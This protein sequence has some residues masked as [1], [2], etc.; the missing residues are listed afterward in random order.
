MRKST[1]VGFDINC[2]HPDSKVAMKWGTWK[3]IADLDSYWN[4]KNLNFCD[5]ETNTIKDAN[6]LCFMRREE[7]DNVYEIKTKFGNKL[8]V[9]GDHPILTT[10]GMVNTDKLEKNDKIITHPFLGVEFEEPTDEFILLESD[11]DKILDE[12]NIGNEGN[13]RNQIKCY[14][15]KL[16]LLEIKY[17]SEKLPI[18]LKIIGFVLGDGVISFV[19]KRKGF[20]HF[21]GKKED[22]E[23][24]QNNIRELG[25]KC[26]E[27][28][29]RQ[30]SYSINTYYGN[31][32]F[33]FNETSI[34]KKS[35]AFAILL[36][37][38]GV[39]YGKK[40]TKSYRVPK[41][42]LKAPLWQKRLFLAAFFGA[43]LSKPAILNKYN[44]YEL[45]LNMNKLKILREN[46][47]DFLNDIRLILSEFD[48]QTSYPVDV[49]GYQYHG[50]EGETC[51][52]RL[53][54]KNNMENFIK[55]FRTVGYEYNKKKRAEACYAAAY[56]KMK[57]VIVEAK[58]SLNSSEG[59]IL[60]TS[61]RVGYGFISYEN[62]KKNIAYGHDGFVVD[63][64][65]TIEKVPFA[66]FVYDVTMNNTNHNFIANSLVVSNCGMRLVTTNL[67]ISEVKP[68]LHE[69]V[70]T[71]FKTVPAGVGVKGFVKP[72][73]NQFHDIMVEGVKWCVDNG[74]GWKEDVERVEEHGVI[75]GADPSK[76]TD[77]AITRGIDQL[78]T[79]GSGNHYLEVQLVTAQNIF[80]AEL[81]EKFGIFKDQ[82][83]VMVHCGSR[84]FG[85]QIA[86][87]YLRIFDDAMKKYNITVNDKELACAPFS[88]KEGQDYY[89]AMACAANMAFANRQVILHRIR[90]GF[91]KV[92]K[93]TPEALEMHMIYDVAHNIAKVEE[94]KL[95]SKKE[96]VLVHRKGS[97]RSFAPGHPD[98]AD[99]YKKTGQPVIIGG[100]METG[101]YLLVGTEKA[102]EDTFGSTAHGSGRTMSRT[103]AKREIRGDK[104]QKDMESRGI[105]VRAA[106]MS[107]L[108]EEAGAAYKNI[109]DVV[110]ALV[111]SG[112]SKPVV[113]LNPIGNVKG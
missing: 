107:G 37:A 5:I 58:I 32:K 68:K 49:N 62:F 64:I 100:S 106:S 104:L 81:A 77:R 57:K 29:E 53:K 48:I 92:F 82:I 88:S 112:I 98:L 74:Y 20:V 33:D 84:G 69:L 27:I 108:A 1:S 30:R 102:M 54:I 10:D 90:E 14:L 101:S 3:K 9:T 8:M 25:F 95:G 50:K 16:G 7:I 96:K 109:T 28:F 34:M 110:D 19:N 31:S 12:I 111:K 23:E 26:P 91:S 45:Q 103:Q 66:G 99:I 46:A 83:V 11:V 94:H 24:I 61:P 86:T 105:Y 51:G 76:V 73:K 72:N 71:F 93:K 56:L 89:K 75:K 97:T 60:K 43:E 6:I 79:L 63:E 42:I 87:D 17:S 35:T 15:K 65:A 2:I 44:F 21:Y 67:T 113:G 22:L 36:V 55:F 80:D 78:G 85:H 18:L 47:I 41:W 59:V 52:L 70:D 40:V 13:A 39:P 38:L 4:S